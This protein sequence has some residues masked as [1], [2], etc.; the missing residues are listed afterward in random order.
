MEISIKLPSLVFE[1][2][3]FASEKSPEQAVVV[4]ELLHRYISIGLV[5][6]HSFMLVYVFSKILLIS[7]LFLYCSFTMVVYFFV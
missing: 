5:S 3:C 4:G 6:L 7:L 1:T 2:I